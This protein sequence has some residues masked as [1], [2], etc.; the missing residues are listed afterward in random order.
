MPGPLDVK[1]RLVEAT[2]R[3]AVTGAPGAAGTALEDDFVLGVTTGTIPARDYEAFV[4]VAHA[5]DDG[6]LASTRVTAP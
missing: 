6:F 2:R 5:A 1:A 4:T 3:I